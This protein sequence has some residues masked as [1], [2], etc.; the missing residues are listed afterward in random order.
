[1]S[2]QVAVIGDAELHA[3]SVK[4]SVECAVHDALRADVHPAAGSHLAIVRYAHLHSLVPVVEVVKE[5]DHHRVGDDDTRSLLAGGKQSEGVTRFDY[6]RLLVCQFLKVFFDEAILK[7]VLAYLSC[8]AVGDK[9]IRIQSN[10]EVQVVVNHYLESLALN[11]T[12]LVLVDRLALYLSLRTPAVGVDAA[13]CAEFLEE[14]L[15]NL[16]MQLGG[17][18]AQ[19]VA[20][21]CDSLFGSE[22]ITSVGSAADA[23][24][25]CR[26]FRQFCTEVYSLYIHG[27]YM[28]VVGRVDRMILLQ[29]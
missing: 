12:S 10:V 11:A 3:A 4:K 2:T 13:A 24:C 8:L 18:V 29:R 23:F 17:E 28:F 9:F 1:M 7:P 22:G 15:S 14:L 27:S 6:E 25:E 16:F 19:S 21:S 20:D 26:H 5:A